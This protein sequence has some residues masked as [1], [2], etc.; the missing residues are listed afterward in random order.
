MW[1]VGGCGEPG[2]ISW[3]AVG[4]RS[5]W[6]VCS[7]IGAVHMGNMPRPYVYALYLCNGINN[8]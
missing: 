8:C 5:M 2:K 4:Y 6:F 7:R 1:S 3:G